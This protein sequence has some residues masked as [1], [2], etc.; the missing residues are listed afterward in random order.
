MSNHNIKKRVT[1]ATGLGVM[2]GRC[3]PDSQYGR[4][5]RHPTNVGCSSF[6]YKNDNETNHDDQRPTRKTWT[7]EDNHLA[8]QC[9]FRSNR[10]QRG[11]RK[12][13]IEIWKEC[14]K[15]QTTSQ[16]L[17]NQ[18]RTIIQKSLFSDLELHEIHQKTHKQN[19]NTV[20]DTSSGV[21]QKQSN[22]K[23]L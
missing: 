21:K 11:Y 14:A 1:Q 4:A 22:E 17:T 9:Y 15:F 19:Y 8:L 5:D 18:V 12:R 10:S 13:M 20:P 3:S 2:I 16:R 23:E 6:K 7:W